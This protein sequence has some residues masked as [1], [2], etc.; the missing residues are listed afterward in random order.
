MKY[1]CHI[2]CYTVELHICI[3][4][5]GILH[6]FTRYKLKHADN[7]TGDDWYRKMQFTNRELS[8]L[9]NSILSQ[10][11]ITD[12]PDSVDTWVDNTPI[13]VQKV[14]I[15]TKYMRHNLCFVYSYL[16]YISDRSDN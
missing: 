1:T 8:S 2:I 10:N 13:V 9:D 16:K 6:L 7:A 12:L 3:V 11:Y 15:S 14:S 4:I 5:I